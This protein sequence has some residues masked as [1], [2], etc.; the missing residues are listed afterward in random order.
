MV[1]AGSSRKFRSYFTILAIRDGIIPPTL[2]LHNLDVE[3]NL[4]FVPNVKKS[5]NSTSKRVAL[6]NAFGFGGTN[7]CL[8]FAQYNE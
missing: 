6:K 3:T 8:C 4:N 5:W 2:N 7:A 1:I